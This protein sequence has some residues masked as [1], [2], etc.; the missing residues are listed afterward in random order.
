MIKILLIWKPFSDKMIYKFQE[1]VDVYYT[2]WIKVTGRNGVTNY[3]HLL[4]SGHVAYYIFKYQNL[5]WYSQKGLK[6]MMAKIKAIY[7]KCTPRGRWFSRRRPEPHP[8]S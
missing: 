3:I 7:H 8:T 5:Y 6:V 1:K 2:K 4:E